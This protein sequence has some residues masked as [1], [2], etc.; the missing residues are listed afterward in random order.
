MQPT[1]IAK[2]GLKR[3]VAGHSK[4]LWL[5]HFATTSGQEPIRSATSGK[6][7]SDTRLSPGKI[8]T[9]IVACLKKT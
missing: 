4:W 8:Y 2:R 1:E 3:N 6:D 7:V 5:S 9:I